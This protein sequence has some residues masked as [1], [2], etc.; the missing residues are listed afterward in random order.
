MIFWRTVR[1]YY[2]VGSELGM[3]RPIDDYFWQYLNVQHSFM[4]PQDPL[5]PSI[6]VR[7]TYH[8]Q[9]RIMSYHLMIRWKFIFSEMHGTNLNLLLSVLNL[10]QSYVRAI[11]MD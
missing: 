4:V 9:C 1:A 5:R 10:R 3:N 6:H 2:L 11:I 8:Y 7:L